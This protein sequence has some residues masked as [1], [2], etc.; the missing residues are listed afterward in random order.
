MRDPSRQA[1]SGIPAGTLARLAVVLA[2]TIAFVEI[3]VRLAYLHFRRTPFGAGPDIIWM[4]PTMNLLWFGGAATLA[5]AG[6]RLIPRLVTGS[7]AFGLLVMPAFLTATWLIP[8]LQLEAAFVLAL[9]L[10]VQSGRV[11]ARR[12]ARLERLSRRSIVPAML[13]SVVACAV[14]LGTLKVR[15]TRAM[16]ALPTA[17]AGVRNVLLIILDTVR[18]FSLSAYGYDRQ[19][20]PTLAQLAES[21]IRFDRAFAPA[22]WT[23]PTHASLFT[24][25]WPFEVRSGP[26]VPLGS[27]HPTLAEALRSA[28]VA[29]GGFAANH[30]YTTWEHGLTRGFIRYDDY[31]VNLAMF[32]TATAIGRTLM[33][34][35]TLRKPLGYF[36]SPKRKTARTVS[37]QF[38]EWVDGL[39][40]RPF[41]AYLN[42]FDAHH[43]YL[44][45][46]PYLTKFGPH[47]VLRWIGHTPE[48]GEL[49]MSEIPLKNN[50]YDGAIA[51]VDAELARMLRTLDER[52]LLEN[53]VIMI[54]ADH[55]EHWGDHQRLAHAN[56]LYRQ[57]LQVPLL[58]VTPNGPAGVRVTRPVSLRDVPA[59]ILDVAGVSNSVML[60]GN[61]LMAMT[62][63]DSTVTASPV[64]SEDAPFGMRG[65]RSLI[66]EGLHYIRL[67]SG[68]EELYDIENDS[69]ER[70]NLVANQSY[71]RTLVRLRARL[72]SIVGTSL[73]S[74]F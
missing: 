54:T 71:T 73:P 28:G 59:T 33:E 48:F 60:P 2:V 70:H 30:F 35:N 23:L 41:F 9:G 39:G 34:Y 18:S 61:S 32:F 47:G 4:A 40:T 7:V 45:P 25:R 31:P 29:T 50:Q 65:A 67:K 66:D 52:G 64:F 15:E 57:V 74:D 69:L 38:L 63:G 14:V 43:P 11:L 5:I 27:N 68:E 24:A 6:H 51:Y 62:D 49:P 46:E 55:G 16:T 44:P 20:S 22:S 1:E 53:T 12:R 19:T 56:S 36:D 72:D 3:G 13:T 42:Y 10:A 8:G 17:S 37:D 26:R 58:I 21:G